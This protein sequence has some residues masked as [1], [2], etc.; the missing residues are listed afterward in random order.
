MHFAG[1]SKHCSLVR[2]SACKLHHLVFE[3]A[4]LGPA[5]FGIAAF[6]TANLILSV[7]R[8]F[9]SAYVPILITFHCLLLSCIHLALCN[10]E[11]MC[12]LYNVRH[13]SVMNSMQ[14]RPCE[15]D[16]CCLTLLMSYTSKTAYFQPQHAWCTD[17]SAQFTLPLLMLLMLMFA[18]GGPQLVDNMT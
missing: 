17:C 10:G 6:G 7:K 2:L 15:H 8:C 12:I 11:C 18:A 14:T 9:G 16:S 1:P 3:T 13:W 4:S 5:S